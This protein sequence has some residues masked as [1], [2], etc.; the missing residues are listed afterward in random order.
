[1]KCEV[2]SVQL[3]GTT[4]FTKD[5]LD[6]IKNENEQD[7]L[8]YLND[9]MKLSGKDDSMEDDEFVMWDM[10]DIIQQTLLSLHSTHQD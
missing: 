8:E 3:V 2:E 10:S 7:A 9:I 1:M 5:R 6:D 4:Y